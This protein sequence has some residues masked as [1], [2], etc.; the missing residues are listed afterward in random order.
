MCREQCG[1]NANWYLVVKVN[2]RPQKLNYEHLNATWLCKTYLKVALNASRS[3][4]LGYN[5]Q[6]TL[7]LKA[8]TDLCRRLAIFTGNCHHLG[9]IQKVGIS[10]FCPRTIRW[11]QRAVCCYWGKGIKCKQI[12]SHY[13]WDAVNF[14][15]RDKGLR[16]ELCIAVHLLTLNPQKW[17][18]CNFSL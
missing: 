1:E 18:T 6:T 3:D 13:V 15:L 11:S 8:D 17:L 4:T 2:F 10:R 7:Y 9:I 5:R 14:R 16:L 12:I